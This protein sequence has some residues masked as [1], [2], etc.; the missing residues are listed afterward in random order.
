MTRVLRE[1]NE[2]PIIPTSGVGE[3]VH[4]VG[5][6][7]SQELVRQEEPGVGDEET[8]R[9]SVN[10]I[11]EDLR[12][13]TTSLIICLRKSWTVWYKIGINCFGFGHDDQWMRC[14]PCRTDGDRMRE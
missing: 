14:I 1:V 11:V 13:K 10:E 2:D 7:A 3:S 8:R 5:T 6:R 9:K 4:E 12:L